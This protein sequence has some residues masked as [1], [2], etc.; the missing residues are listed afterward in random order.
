MPL[1]ACS[2][3]PRLRDL[4]GEA[5]CVLGAIYRRLE[6]PRTHSER[7]RPFQTRQVLLLCFPPNQC[8][9]L[10]FLAPGSNEHTSARVYFGCQTQETGMFFKQQAD[11]ATLPTHDAM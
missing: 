5:V 10:L 6:H 9:R 2:D 4:P 3:G 11:G 8:A 7:L 1:E